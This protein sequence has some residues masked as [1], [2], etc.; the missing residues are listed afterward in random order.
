MR[1]FSFY[2]ISYFFYLVLCPH[3]REEATTKWQRAAA[4]TNKQTHE[5]LQ[6]LKLLSTMKQEVS[7][8]LGVL[9]SNQVKAWGRFS[10]TP[11]Q[12]YKNKFWG[13]KN[14]GD[15]KASLLSLVLALKLT[16]FTTVLG[17]CGAF[18]LSAGGTKDTK[19]CDSVVHLWMT[20]P[21]HEFKSYIHFTEDPLQTKK[22][23]NI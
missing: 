6:K 13:E 9:P 10:A 23:N 16:T 1:R 20:T 17:E 21:L 3:Q 14:M 5:G 22:S 11:I 19:A 7:V 12:G 4:T 8:S 15:I 18:S 2:Y